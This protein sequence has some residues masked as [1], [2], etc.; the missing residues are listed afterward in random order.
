MSGESTLHI[1]LVESLE[2]QVRARHAPPRGLLLLLDHDRYGRDRPHRCDRY[3][4]DL[5]ASDLPVTFEIVGEA[6]T[7]AD[8]ERPR[9]HLQIQGFL[10]Y[11][12]LR[13][14]SWLYLCVPHPT[15]ARAR[16]IV[17]RLRRPEHAAVQIEVLAGD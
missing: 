4:P 1:R 5:F 2:R 16:E 9:S 11:L 14:L 7:P 10:D 13:P 8:L 6:K 3:C 12:S 15:V 17:K